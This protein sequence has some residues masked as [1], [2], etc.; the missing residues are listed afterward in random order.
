MDIDGVRAALLRAARARSAAAL[1][2]TPDALVEVSVAPGACWVA[3][4][5][6]IEWVGGPDGLRCWE[7]MAAGA[8]PIT[9]TKP[10]EWVHPAVGILWP[11]ALPIWG[12]LGDSHRPDRV[13]A[14]AAGP[15]QLVLTPVNTDLTAAEGALDMDPARWLC[16]RL[17]LSDTEWVLR[18]YRDTPARAH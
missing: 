6:S 7:I 10:A 12:R 3:R 14:G 5:H 17:D 2:A 1:V 9:H 13:I 8:R 4:S 15:G 16:L 11:D 18:E